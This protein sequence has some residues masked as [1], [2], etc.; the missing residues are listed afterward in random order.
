MAT[1]FYLPS[2]GSSPVSPSFQAVWD[3]TTSAFVRKMSPTKANSSLA[4]DH[5]TNGIATTVDR[6]H[7]QYISD[8]IQGG[9]IQGTVYGIIKCGEDN[10]ANNAQPQAVIYVV[11][12]AG[13]TVRGVLVPEWTGGNVTASYEFNVISSGANAG[14]QEPFPLQCGNGGGV[15]IVP[16]AVTPVLA[17]DGDRIVFEVGHTAFASSSARW[18]ELRWGDTTGGADLNTTEGQTGATSSNAWLEFSEDLFTVRSFLSYSR[19]IG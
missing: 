2:T 11:D 1:K 10:G 3:V 4:N 16:Y 7:G 18:G 6:L 9:L 14:S 15:A 17:Q 8:G 12:N 13:T 19:S 5:Y